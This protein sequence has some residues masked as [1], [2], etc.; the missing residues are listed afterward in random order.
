M[1]DKQIIIEDCPYFVNGVCMEY[2]DGA[3]E[4]HK[5]DLKI[6]RELE[7][8]LQRKKKQNDELNK[9]IKKRNEQIKNLNYTLF[10]DRNLTIDLAKANLKISKLERNFTSMKGRYKYELDKLRQTLTEIKEMCKE[11]KGWVNCSDMKL[12]E[13]AQFAQQIFDKI[14][15]VED[16]DKT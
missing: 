13:T 4:N 8:Q 6:I 15:E 7:E 16:A 2:L 3:C 12:T 1:T 14:S 10:E 11:E 5:C 9:I